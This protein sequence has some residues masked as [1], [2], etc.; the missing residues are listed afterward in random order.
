MKSFEDVLEDHSYPYQVT[1]IVSHFM[2]CEEMSSLSK[3][4]I[5]QVIIHVHNMKKR[6]AKRLEL[7]TTRIDSFGPEEK[8]EKKRTICKIQH[9][10]Y[11]MEYLEDYED[12]R[13]EEI[14]R[15]N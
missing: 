7:L 5:S 10:M 1:T 8:N 13:T 12:D 15:Y 6:L 2:W 14:I 3:K 4:G 11:C 9:L